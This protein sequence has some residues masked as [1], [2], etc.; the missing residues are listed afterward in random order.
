MQFYI[1]TKV[2]IEENCVARHKEIFSQYGT[3]AFIVTGKHSSKI[4]GSLDDV[5]SALSESGITYEIFSEVEENPSVETVVK[6]AELGKAFRADFV[7]GIGGGSPLDASK[8]IALLINNPE[9]TG[10]TLTVLKDIQA[11]PVISVPTT[12]GTGSEV[13][14]VSVL[15]YHEKKTKGSIPY[16]IYPEAA[17]VDGK[18]LFG[19]KKSLIVGTSI[20]ALAHC[21]ESY[22]SVKANTYN[23]MFSSYGLKLWGGIKA[24]LASPDPLNPQT[25]QQLMLVSTVAG[26]AIAH[27]GTSL[28]HAMS[29]RV[30]YKLGLP[31]GKACGL[32][33]TAYMREYAKHNPEIISQ[34]LSLMGFETLETFDTCLRSLMDPVSVSEEEM[35][36]FAET[37]MT[38][39]KAKLS[40]YPYEIDKAAVTQIFRSSFTLV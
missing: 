37:F 40:S 31:H 33:L 2:F 1:P 26:M 3:R 11:L 13:T 29:Y 6:A 20:D 17:L 7:I 8:A 36:S 24:L 38:H 23:R 28:P 12:C 39:D 34:V 16:R 21:L 14:G 10:E 35:L 22:L 5:T 19:A 30:T 32:F 27:T 18:Y 9:E 15:T 25:A 4:N